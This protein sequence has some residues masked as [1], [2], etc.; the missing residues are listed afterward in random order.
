MDR[1]RFAAPAIGACVCL[2]AGAGIEHLRL[3]LSAPPQEELAAQETVR[4]AQAPECVVTVR[5]EAAEREAQALRQRVAQ[6]EGALAERA[7]AGQTQ[8]EQDEE[9]ASAQGEHS[10]RQS[11]SWEDRME[12]MRIEDPDRYAEMQQR[13]ESF[14]QNMEQRARDRADF[15]DA[16]DVAGMTR[17]QRANH[18]KLLDITA[19]LEELRAQMME[20]GRPRGEGGEA[21]RQEMSESMATLGQL[22]EAER[23]YLIEATAKAAGYTGSDI[24]A[25]S[26]H[27][28]NIIENTTMMPGFGGRGG[29]GGGFGRGGGR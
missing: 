19:R 18:E 2:L 4:V 16:I 21:L 3:K 5:D 23:Q 20:G 7:A 1:K 25:F 29:P 13:R 14:R 26:D 17:E 24:Q 12:R 6:L 11:Q 27:I 10:G 28:Q 15:L 22:Y 9:P 8:S